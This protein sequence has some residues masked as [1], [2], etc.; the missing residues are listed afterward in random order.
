MFIEG[1]PFNIN[2]SIEFEE[3]ELNH[4]NVKRYVKGKASW[5]PDITLYDQNY[6]PIIEW[7]RLVT[8]LL[9][10]V[11]GIVISTRKMLNSTY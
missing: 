5:Q 2:R 10:D 3:V 6:V 1:V 9:Q 7:I 4:I 8:S 11:M